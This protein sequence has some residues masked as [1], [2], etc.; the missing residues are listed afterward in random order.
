MRPTGPAAHRAPIF[1]RP[2]EKRCECVRGTR[3]ATCVRVCLA[4]YASARGGAAMTLTF[5]HKFLRR[6]ARQDTEDISV[7][8]ALSSGSPGDARHPHGRVG[9]GNMRAV[10]RVSCRR[11]SWREILHRI[12]NRQ[13]RMSNVHIRNPVGA[14][15]AERVRNYVCATRRVLL[16]CANISERITNLPGRCVLARNVRDKRIFIFTYI[17]TGARAI[18]SHYDTTAATRMCVQTSAGGVGA[19][20]LCTNGVE[21]GCRVANSSTCI[22]G[23][24]YK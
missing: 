2:A 14:K 18:V 22:S 15:G 9:G 4:K 10:S 19:R 8:Q 16:R 24:R 12:H 13:L 23:V 17:T 5:A 3:H 7:R 11:A 21:G 1:G 20:N 6:A